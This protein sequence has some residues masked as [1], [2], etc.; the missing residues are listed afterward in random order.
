MAAETLEMERGQ[1][2]AE[3]GREHLERNDLIIQEQEEKKQKNQKELVAGCLQ[4]ASL[5]LYKV[6]DGGTY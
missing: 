2:K 5:T 4:I 6:I 1:R 3:T